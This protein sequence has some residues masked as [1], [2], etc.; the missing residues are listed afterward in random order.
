VDPDRVDHDAI[1]DRVDH[2]AIVDRE[3]HDAIVDRVDHDAIVDR[4]DHDAIVDRVDHDAIVIGAGHNGL[5]AAA[6]L[7]RARMRTL[8]L[9]ARSEIGGTA[10][11]E[12]F[13]GATVNICNCDHITF[14]TTPIIE[15]LRLA[16]HGLRYLDVEPAQLTV[17]WSGGPAWTLHH[18]VGATLD[19]LAASYP[20]EVD[21]YRRY[22]AAATPAVRLVLDAA[23]APPRPAELTRLA[24]RRRLAGVPTLFRWAR[25]SAADVLRAHFRHDA[26][27]GSALVTGPMVWGVSPEQPGTGLGALTHALRHVGRVGRPRGGSGAL[28]DALRAAFERAGGAVRLSSP[29]SAIRC[30]RSRVRGVALADG[31]EIAA[32]IVVSAC[33]PHR[34]IVSWLTE[35]PDA[36]RAMI[37]R[38]RRRTQQAGYESKLD[39]VLD[40][41]PRLRGIPDPLVP[42]TVV[43][44]SPGEIHRGHDLMTAGRVLPHP[45][46]L[47]NVPTALDPSLAPPGRHVLSVEA[48]FT[49]YGLEGGWPGSS[50]PERWLRLVAGLCEPG[51]LESVVDWR[52]MT[53]DVYEREFHL[54]SGHAASF[55]GGP[56]AA[57]R[58]PE[59][60]LTRYETAV[61]GLY[62]TGA[63]TFPGAGIWGASGRNCAAVILAARA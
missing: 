31:T 11:S 24:V 61:D 9:E 19:S 13:A 43:A 57:V 14:R 12:R 10:A 35:P 30:D 58:S 32:P 52:A 8:L 18:D 45:G 16:D 37:E 62:L 63:A 56:L 51:L 20:D 15:E 4:V 60:E 29:V 38:W 33:D 3:D 21:G 22:V 36:A 6:Y 25:R 46:L 47:V 1:V 17:P 26:L 42:T 53:P 34:T 40:A 41:P 5:V 49:P 2:D 59:P 28:P 50:E 39:V 27:I 48:L 54:P 44:P 23:A 7:A 55:A